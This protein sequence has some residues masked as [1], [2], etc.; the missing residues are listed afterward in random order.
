VY[1]TAPL[2]KRFATPYIHEMLTRWLPK[3]GRAGYDFWN[4]AATGNYERDCAE[5]ERLASEYVLRMQ[6]QP[7]PAMLGWIARDMIAKGR[8]S[9]VEVG[10]F[11]GISAHISARSAPRPAP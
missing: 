2:A 3:R 1:V 10:F 7:R 9:G 8:F 6:M 5:G 4:A 11:Q